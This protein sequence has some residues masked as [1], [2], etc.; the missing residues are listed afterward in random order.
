MKKQTFFAV[1]LTAATALCGCIKNV[2]SH[3]V[4]D[5]R[6]ARAEQSRAQAELFR[7]QAA[8]Q[9]AQVAL[10]NAQAANQQ[11]MTDYQVIQNR[12]GE[13][14]ARQQIAALEAQMQ[15]DALNHQVALLQA[16]QALETALAGQA[17]AKANN[18]NT[19]L[20][21]YVNYHTQLAAAQQQLFLAQAEVEKVRTA[22]YDANEAVKRQY[23]TLQQGLASLIKEYDALK[24]YREA[25]FDELKREKA[26]TLEEMNHASM[27]LSEAMAASTAVMQ[28]LFSQANHIQ[29]D[30]QYSM[31]GTGLADDFLT[32]IAYDVN[33]FLT[34]YI[35]Y[36]AV[37]EGS[38][39]YGGQLLEQ[40]DPV[41]GWA[42]ETY[43][44]APP[45][46][47]LTT[48]TVMLLY[49]DTDFQYM[50]NSTTS[51]I[52]YPEAID[53]VYPVGHMMLQPYKWYA[54]E[55]NT[56]NFTAIYNAAKTALESASPATPQALADL[57]AAWQ[58]VSSAF[59]ALAAAKVGYL[60]EVTRFNE[61]ADL[62]IGSQKAVWDCND[63]LSG[64]TAEYNAI[65]AMLDLAYT[66]YDANGTA[67]TMSVDQRLT[68]LE[69][70]IDT[71]KQQIDAQ[72]NILITNDFSVVQLEE[73]LASHVEQCQT[74]VNTLMSIVTMIKAELDKAVA[75][76]TPTL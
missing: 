16:Q 8:V 12:L 40:F 11:A 6:Y 29:M 20:A 43:Y 56:E 22:T 1:L 34:T 67:W 18:V 58:K 61:I 44:T 38:V 50:D 75:A 64:A 23:N 60:K 74:N 41:F 68:E 3:S 71:Q 21:S 19:L 48:P 24:A 7:A 13:A 5:L 9:A 42:T 57:E 39:T 51:T 2:E 46:S 35:Q 62:Y 15:V 10:V 65:V 30:C 14:Q 17:D 27:I 54:R 59:P 52:H 66:G 72:R 28:D 53:G 63:E 4:T 32:N 73:S 26:T 49:N 76:L 70:L 25:D 33:T 69:G 47:G 45:A 36:T 37:T 31:T 55:I